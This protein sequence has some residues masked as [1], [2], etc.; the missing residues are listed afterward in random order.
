[1]NYIKIL[2]IILVVAGVITFGIDAYNLK[3]VNRNTAML[4]DFGIIW[5][6]LWLNKAYGKAAKKE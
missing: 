5:L 6:G 1:M 3:G 4:L 2:S